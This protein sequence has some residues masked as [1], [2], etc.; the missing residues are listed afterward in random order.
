M[1]RLRFGELDPFVE[2]TYL[3]AIDRLHRHQLFFSLPRPLSDRGCSFAV[4]LMPTSRRVN[5]TFTFR[6]VFRERDS[7]NLF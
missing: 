2:T 1:P 3:S 7:L 6:R 5:F 4:C